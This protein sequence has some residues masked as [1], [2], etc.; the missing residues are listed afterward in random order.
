M[1]KGSGMS[2]ELIFILA[3]VV[4]I[5]GIYKY[6]KSEMNDYAALI[7]K[8][9]HQAGEINSL[10]AD[11]K[12]VEDFKIAME[13]FDRKVID[14]G[15]DVEQSQDHN[16]KLRE[17]VIELRDKLSRRNPIT[18]VQGPIMVEIHSTKPQARQ[19]APPKIPDGPPVAPQKPDPKLL[20]KVKKQ[21][22][23]LS[24]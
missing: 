22:Q 24:R 17:A 19:Q 9:N 16:A 10:K 1:G 2:G 6:N 23:E 15:N 4:A 8:M 3:M 7:D 14:L 12:K 11:L 18:R 20:K 21:V 13:A 5:F